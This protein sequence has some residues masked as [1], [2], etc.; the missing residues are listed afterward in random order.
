MKFNE[1]VHRHGLARVSIGIISRESFERVSTS[2][3]NEVGSFSVVEGHH[4]SSNAVSPLLGHLEE[5][6]MFVETGTIVQSFHGKKELSSRDS[7][8][9]N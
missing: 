6:W 8:N 9:R 1:P 5:E 3:T 2:I 4:G 7:L